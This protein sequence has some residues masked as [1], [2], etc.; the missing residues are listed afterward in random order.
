MVRRSLRAAAEAAPPLSLNVAKD[1]CDIRSSFDPHGSKRRLSNAAFH[2][3]TLIADHR[4]PIE[5]VAEHRR[6]GGVGHGA[7][8]GALLQRRVLVDQRLREFGACFLGRDRLAIDLRR[9]RFAPREIGIEHVHIEETGA[10]IEI[11]D[12]TIGA[13]L[14]RE[15][16]L[17]DAGFVLTF[18]A[19]A[20]LPRLLTDRRP[21]GAGGA[22]AERRRARDQ[23]GDRDGTIGE[24]AAGPAQAFAGA[25]PW[26][27]RKSCSSP[28]SYISRTMSQ[29]P[30]N[31][32]FT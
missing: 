15:R 6:R 28:F 24:K 21:V 2:L 16:R 29:P 25:T 26:S 10:R 32:P 13:L 4:H 9:D 11:A 30:T 5:P 20:K 17:D 19:G 12:R 8:R 22:S 7:A 27:L 14:G 31:S 1:V 23:G 3:E 18:A